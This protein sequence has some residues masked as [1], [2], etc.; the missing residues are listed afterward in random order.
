[1]TAITA[2][3][4]VALPGFAFF[5][6]NL[7]AL[8]YVVPFL[9][10]MLFFCITAL[11]VKGKQFVGQGERSGYLVFSVLVLLSVLFYYHSAA[12]MPGAASPFA[13]Y[14]EKTSPG[15]LEYL[16]A[17]QVLSSIGVS[18]CFLRAV[19]AVLQPR[20]AFWDF[21]RYYLFFPTFFSGPIIGV[22]EYLAQTPAFRRSNLAPAMVRIIIG[23]MKLA[24]SQLLQAFMPLSSSAA[25]MG[26]IQSTSVA[27]AW[28]FAFSAGVWLYL[29][30]SGFSDLCIGLAKLCN[31][32]A[33][34]NFNNPFAARDITDFWRRWHI[35]LAAWLRTCIYTPVTKLLGKRYGH[36]HALLYIFPPIITMFICGLWHGVSPGYIFWGLMH[37]LGLV[38]HQ[39][40]KAAIALWCPGSFRESAPYKLLAW[41]VTH[42]Y[43]GA[44][45]VFFFPSPNPSLQVSFLYF[46][47]MFGVGSPEMD[48]AIS[49]LAA[50]A[51][52]FLLGL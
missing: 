15:L 40:Y 6:V 44:T 24:G 23:G 20:L 29:N 31:I 16:R 47:R 28:F 2:R 4:S 32:S 1:M 27:G 11:L 35:T 10:L 51:K 38:V 22:E 37:G 9:S 12:A 43:V 17:P 49:N 52:V 21:A 26:Q 25:M 8:I 7:L 5:L 42:A 48:M 50:T 36:Q 18:Y 45:W 33:P 46:T 13:W 41:L 34:E 39:G 3:Q 14:F 30:F 19:Y